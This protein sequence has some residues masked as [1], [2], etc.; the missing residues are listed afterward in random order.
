MA[1][2]QHVRELI[3]H[4]TYGTA[5]FGIVVQRHTK[6]ITAYAPIAGKTVRYNHHD[7]IAILKYYYDKGAHIQARILEGYMQ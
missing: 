2:K 1:D 3:Y 7:I 4:I 5:T 6:E